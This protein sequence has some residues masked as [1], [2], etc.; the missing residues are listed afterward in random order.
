MIKMKIGSEEV[1]K[2]L[3]DTLAIT[4]HYNVFILK[5]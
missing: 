5:D 2:I 1:R 4:T 3:S